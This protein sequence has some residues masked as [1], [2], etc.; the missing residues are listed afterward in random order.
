MHELR[1]RGRDENEAICEMCCKSE[2]G[3]GIQA[4]QIHFVWE[5]PWYDAEYDLR[6]HEGRLPKLGDVVQGQMRSVTKEEKKEFRKRAHKA[7]DDLWLTIL[8]W[9][10]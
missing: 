8:D 3:K 9:C 4:N 10:G 2:V 5:G 7:P 6:Q 1:D